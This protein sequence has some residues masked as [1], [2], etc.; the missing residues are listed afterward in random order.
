MIDP[1]LE[2]P[3]RFAGR[4]YVLVG[5]GSYS[6]AVL[7][8]NVMQDFGFATL[9]GSGEAART[10]QSGGVQRSIRPHSGLVIAVPRLILQRP[11]G[12]ETPQYV[13]PDLLVDE[14]PV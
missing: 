2:S 8:A 12:A 4:T 13:T 11:S 5:R 14:D 10:R 6:S 9:A 1:P 3:L 7:F